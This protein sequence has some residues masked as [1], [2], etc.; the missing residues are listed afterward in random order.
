MCKVPFWKKGISPIK[1]KE[2]KKTYIYTSSDFEREKKKSSNNHWPLLTRQLFGSHASK[3]PVK[4]Q[5]HRH[6]PPPRPGTG[7]AECPLTPHRNPEPRCAAPRRAARTSRAPPPRSDLTASSTIRRSCV[8]ERSASPRVASFPRCARPS[9]SQALSAVVRVHWGA[10]HR[11]TRTLHSAA[12]RRV[13]STR[14]R[15]AA[16]S[17]AFLQTLPCM[18]PQPIRAAAESSGGGTKAFKVVCGV[19]ENACDNR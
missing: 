10:I 16:T 17:F 14:P 4:P 19:N 7:E 18:G 3:S 2:E 9:A 8:L 6:G 1:K 12:W 11:H 5:V 15:E 13:R